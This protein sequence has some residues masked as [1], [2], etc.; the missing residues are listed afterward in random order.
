MAIA[1]RLRQPGADELR[2]RGCGHGCEAR[3]PAVPV[4][5]RRRSTTRRVISSR[6]SKCTGCTRRYDSIGTTARVSLARTARLLMSPGPGSFGGPSVTI[7]D[8]DYELD[9]ERTPWGDVRRLRPPVTVPGVPIRWG[10]RRDRASVR[11]A[12]PGHDVAARSSRYVVNVGS[13][14]AIRRIRSSSP[15]CLQ[16]VATAISAAARAG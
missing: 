16:T 7:N 1:A 9:V 11:P 13:S 15:W 5:R 14:K 10:P 8:D 6:R 12:R 3:R 2:Y 4:A